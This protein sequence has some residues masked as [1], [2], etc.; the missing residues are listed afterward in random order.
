MTDWADFLDKSKTFQQF[1]YSVPDKDSQGCFA[2][3]T[4][5]GKAIR[6]TRNAMRRT[7]RKRGV[8][9][10]GPCVARSDEG[11]L[12]RSRQAKAVW[13]NPETAHA[14]R[15]K[16]AKIARSIAGRKQRSLQAKLAWATPEFAE[17][18]RARIAIRFKSVAHRNLVSERNKSDYIANP[19]EYLRTRTAALQSAQAKAAHKKALSK[20]E[21]RQLHAE[22]ARIRF[23][24]PVYKAKIAAGLEGFPC[25]GRQSVPETAV[26]DILTGLGCEFI[27]NKSIGPYNFDFFIE[28]LDLFIEVQG[29]Y[30]HTLS[31][32]ERRDRAKYTYLRSTLPTSKIVYIWDYDLVTGAA[33]A[34]LAQAVGVASLPVQ[35]FSFHEVSIRTIDSALAKNF[36]NT[37]HYA[38]SGKSGKFIVGAFLGDQLVAVAKLGPVSRKEVATSLGSNPRETFELDRLCIHPM[39]QKQKQNFASYFLSRAIASFFSAFPDAMYVVAFSDETF[40]HDGTVYKACNWLQVGTVRPDYV[41]VRADGW[42]MHKKTLYNQALSVHMTEKQYAQQNGWVKVFGKCKHKFVLARSK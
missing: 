6:T 4:L 13:E 19:E 39:K 2:I 42:S 31:N 33:G 40:G 12:A 22:L 28:K 15:E 3:C 29:E 34:K 10:C 27:Y 17:S 7:V 5:C 16:S 9:R 11:R 21:Y 26:R 18:Q 24:D 23:Q 38:Q 8:Y 14:I 1:G 41:Y 25:G 35:D 36:L 32:N 30:W 20:P 37:W